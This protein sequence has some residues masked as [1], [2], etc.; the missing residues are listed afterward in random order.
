MILTIIDV[1][2]CAV[3]VGLGSAITALSGYFV[4][5]RNQSFKFPPE[6]YGG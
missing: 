5:K 4:L 1:L 2:D 6:K 3:K